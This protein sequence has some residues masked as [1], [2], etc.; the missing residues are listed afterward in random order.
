MKIHSSRF[1]LSL[2]ILILFQTIAFSLPHTEGN[3]S[4][5][6]TV[7][8]NGKVVAQCNQNVW[9]VD[10]FGTPP[11]YRYAQVKLII[12]GTTVYESHIFDLPHAQPLLP[13]INVSWKAEL[14]PGYHEVMFFLGSTAGLG[15]WPENGNY[16]W[17]YLWTGTIS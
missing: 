17:S 2:L 3:G 8:G 10:A 4:K 1:Q 16:G 5:S 14:G 6:F 13:N 7:Y 9:C 11:S 12:D 15:F